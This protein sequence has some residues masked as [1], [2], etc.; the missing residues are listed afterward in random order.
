[1]KMAEYYYTQNPESAHQL[2]TF[3]VEMGDRLLEF[4]T[5][6]GVFSKEH[7]DPGSQ[8]QCSA[9]P[10]EMEGRILDMGAGWG[11]MS[12]L[13]LAAHPGL[14]L[15]MAEI[16]ERA[17]ELAKGNLARNGMNGRA[18][19]SDGFGNVEGL[20]ETIVTNPPIRAGKTV[21]YGM[22]RDAREHLVPGGSLYL[23]IRKQQGAE[24]AG[25]YLKELYET[26]DIV[27][28]KSGY[29]VYRCTKGTEHA[30]I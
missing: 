20:F 4:E 15:T 22:F 30:E 14:D 1:M 27:K 12:V 24:S 6:A 25:K 11:A 23:V 7:I 10:E 19:L 26:V 21:I 17:L 8:L 28:K 5:D 29:V 18:L 3:T 16:N 2:R 13:I 9:L